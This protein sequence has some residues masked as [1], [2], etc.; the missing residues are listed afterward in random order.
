MGTYEANG[1]Q[2]SDNIF[3]ENICKLWST[4]HIVVIILPS[5]N[6][7]VK[8]TPGNTIEGELQRQESATLTTEFSS[9]PPQ[10]QT[11][12]E[13]MNDKGENVQSQGGKTPPRAH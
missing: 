3:S 8:P 2:E 9:E 1:S 5:S 11:K 6:K 4:I 12:Q 13:N 7:I 10:G